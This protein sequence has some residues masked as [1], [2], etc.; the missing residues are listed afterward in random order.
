M[1]MRKTACAWIVAAAVVATASAVVEDSRL[2]Q[3]RLQYELAKSDSR[4]PRYGDCW[5]SAVRD[6]EE[7]CKRLTDDEQGGHPTM[8]SILIT[9]TSNSVTWWFM[10]CCSFA[11]GSSK[12][13]L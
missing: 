10:Y 6:L 9:T 8:R 13:C 12:R 4:L 5:K 3:G 11:I 2:E 1:M 7:G